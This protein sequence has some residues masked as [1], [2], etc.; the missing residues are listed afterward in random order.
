MV[1]LSL[2]KKSNCLKKK[3]RFLGFDISKGQIRP[4]DRAIQ[5]ADKFPDIIIDKT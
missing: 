2:L 4:I 5:F 3:V 1:L